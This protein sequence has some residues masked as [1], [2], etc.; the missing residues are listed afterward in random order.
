[1]KFEN[2]YDAAMKLARYLEKYKNEAGIILAVPRGGVPIGFYL[3][4]HLNFPLELMLTKKIG[5]PMNEELA[6]GAVSL[7]GEVIDTRYNL[8]TSFLAEKIR[9]IRSALKERYYKFMGSRKPADMENITV[10]LVDDGIATGNTM[11]ASIKLIRQ[12]N[13]KKLIVAVPVAPPETAERLS[14][15][16]DDFIC[17]YTPDNFAG[18]GQFYRDFSQVTD[19]EVIKF[20]AAADRF[21]KVA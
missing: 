15:L 12:K 16:V 11:Y 17:L 14:E 2:R 5:H 8:S 10:I 9:N 21:R 18:V 19:E 13:P 6:I 20:M 7:E 3:S 4:R 1:M